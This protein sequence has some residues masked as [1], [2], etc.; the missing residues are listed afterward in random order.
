MGGA[1]IVRKKN[2]F[3]IF[4]DHPNLS[5]LGLKLGGQLKYRIFCTLNGFVAADAIFSGA[6]DA[7]RWNPI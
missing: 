2:V 1:I 6:D 3:R 5:K 4:Q 7:N